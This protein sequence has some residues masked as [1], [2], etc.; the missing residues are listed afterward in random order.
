MNFKISE[1]TNDNQKA[2]RKIIY[3]ENY[4]IHS[5]FCA[6]YNFSGNFFDFHFIMFSYVLK[7]ELTRML[8]HVR[9]IFSCRVSLKIL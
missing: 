6:T 3:G 8:I 9:K 4:P 5:D 7:K 2:D 1:M